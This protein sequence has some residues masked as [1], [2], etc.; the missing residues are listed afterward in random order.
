MIIDL[1]SPGLFIMDK[2]N[3]IIFEMKM[4]GYNI[5]K[6]IRTSLLAM[7]FFLTNEEKVM[8]FDVNMAALDLKQDMIYSIIFA[9]CNTTNQITINELSIMKFFITYK[10]DEI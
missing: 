3:R 8:A 9:L 10:K 2:L 7:I 1:R 5:N 6:V 4:K